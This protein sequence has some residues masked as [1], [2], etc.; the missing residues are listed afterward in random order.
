MS[1]RSTARCLTHSATVSFSAPAVS[2]DPRLTG[3]VQREIAGRIATLVADD[4]A[5]QLGIGYVNGHAAS[6]SV[7]QQARDLVEKVAHPRS[8]RAH[9]SGWFSAAPAPDIRHAGDRGRLAGEVADVGCSAKMRGRGRSAGVAVAL[10]W[11]RARMEA[12]GGRTGRGRKP[13]SV[14]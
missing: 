4:A 11:I 10:T 3:G 6:W 9:R 2:P 13:S 1:R 5:P 8:P 14:R 12:V 7:R